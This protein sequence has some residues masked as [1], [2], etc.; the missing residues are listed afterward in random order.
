M[1]ASTRMWRGE[2]SSEQLKEMG[3]WLQ[4]LEETMR[5]RAYLWRPHSTWWKRKSRR[6]GPRTKG[7]HLFSA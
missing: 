7:T 4:E 5:N 6:G 3:L 2:G 1:G